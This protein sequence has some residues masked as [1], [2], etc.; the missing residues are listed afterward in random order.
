[1]ALY[2]LTDHVGIPWEDD[3]LRLG[4]ETRAKMTSRFEEVLTARG[5]SWLKV[6]GSRSARLA[7]SVDAI[8][9]FFE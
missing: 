5:V 8:G 4:V 6:T 2:L 9:T 1:M 3:G 7:R